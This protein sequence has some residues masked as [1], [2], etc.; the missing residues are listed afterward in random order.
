MG[1]DMAGAQ[2]TLV[3]LML[4]VLS[5]AATLPGSAQSQAPAFV[6]C[7]T[8]IREAKQA[9]Q[10]SAEEAQRL[11]KDLKNLEDRDRK[12]GFEQYRLHGGVREW[13]MKHD[14]SVSFEVQSMIA[15]LPSSPP[16]VTSHA[17]PIHG[18]PTPKFP[19]HDQAGN[20]ILGPLKSGTKEQIGWPMYGWSEADR[21]RFLQQK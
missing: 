3:A 18:S 17:P 16:T 7:A 12:Y 1:Q 8:K 14:P 4:M 21:L 13:W 19:P 5:T 10:I 9:G 20:I 2:S 11:S 6:Q 15:R